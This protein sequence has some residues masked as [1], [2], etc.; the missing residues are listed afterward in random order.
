[1]EFKTGSEGSKDRI[2]LKSGESIKGV[3]MGDTYEFKQHWKDSKPSLCPG[4]TECSR[5]ASGEKASFRFQ[6][7]LIVKEN[8]TYVA[9]VFEQGW[10]VFLD[11]KALHEGGYDLEKYLVKITRNGS[12]MNDTTYSIVPVPNGL[13][14]AAQLKEIASVKLISLTNEVPKEASKNNSYEP[15]DGDIPF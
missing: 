6:L 11:L 14:T 4:E 1:M 3:F 2:K 8:D 10:K 15:V 12:T 13:L 9:K 7:N 5:C